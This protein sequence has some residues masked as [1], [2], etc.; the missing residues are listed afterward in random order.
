MFQIYEKQVIKILDG[1]IIP[2]SEL[3]EVM[4]LADKKM[5]N[6]FPFALQFTLNDN[7]VNKTY[8]TLTLILF[9]NLTFYEP[10]LFHF[11][12]CRYLKIIVVQYC[13][14]YGEG[15]ILMTSMNNFYHLISSYFYSFNIFKLP[16]AGR[17]Y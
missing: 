11:F 16:Q 13:K 15:F 7:K 5:E 9:R 1:E 2:T 14:L 4:T 8:F 10:I 6:A 3:V 17:F 12:N